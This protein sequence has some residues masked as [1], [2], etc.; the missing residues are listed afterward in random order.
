MR[1]ISQRSLDQVYKNGDSER[2]GQ[3]FGVCNVTTNT[4][5]YKYANRVGE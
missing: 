2:V 5:N 1:F 4:S 3:L